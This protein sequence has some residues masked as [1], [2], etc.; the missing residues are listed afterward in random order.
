[1]VFVFAFD[2]TTNRKM[3][4]VNLPLLFI[5]LP[6]V[7]SLVNVFSI[8]ALGVDIPCIGFSAIVAGVFGY[9]AFSTLH[10]IKEYFGVKFERGIFQHMWVILFIN[11]ALIL[12][13]YGYYLAFRNHLCLNLHI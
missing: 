7:S 1:M 6:L 8:S 11:L 10:F 3:L 2:A 13:I 12:S 5:V 9:L 4:F